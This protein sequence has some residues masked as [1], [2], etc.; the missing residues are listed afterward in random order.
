[1][2]NAGRWNAP[3]RFILN[4]PKPLEDF[5]PTPRASLSEAASSGVNVLAGLTLLR[6]P[7]Q[8]NNWGQPGKCSQSA[9]FVL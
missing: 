1:M 5:A 3:W 6:P 4:K 8:K 2:R 7:E 9:L